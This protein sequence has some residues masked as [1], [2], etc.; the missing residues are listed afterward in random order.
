LRDLKETAE[1]ARQRHHRATPAKL[2]GGTCLW[3]GAMLL[4]FVALL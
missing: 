4:Y 1:P 3:F 2:M